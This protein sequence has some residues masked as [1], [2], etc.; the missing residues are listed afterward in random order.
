MSINLTKVNKVFTE[1]RN[2]SV[3]GQLSP[4][5]QIADGL[6]RSLACFPT[7]DV[8]SI[9][10]LQLRIRERGS[11]HGRWRRVSLLSRA[12]LERAP[13]SPD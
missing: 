5:E 6:I 7:V 8:P 12:A 1:G 2:V 11:S 3:V 13:Q 9:S 4:A 10:V